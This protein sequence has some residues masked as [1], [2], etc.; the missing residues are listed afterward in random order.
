M[1][2]RTKTQNPVANLKEQSCFDFFLVW[3]QWLGDFTD[4]KRFDGSWLRH[5]AIQNAGDNRDTANDQDIRAHFSSGVL[6]STFTNV[7]YDYAV[8]F[9]SFAWFGMILIIFDL[10]PADAGHRNK[11]TL[12]VFVRDAAVFFQKFIDRLRK[13]LIGFSNCW[14]ETEQLHKKILSR[15]SEM[16]LCQLKRHFSDRKVVYSDRTLY[17]GE[18]VQFETRRRL[19][20]RSQLETTV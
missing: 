3:R 18:R 8:I 14:I 5:K 16:S 4:R 20:F 17:H 6:R 10:L 15:P 1:F 9:E 7:L 2:D 19:L 12:K 13:I 11:I